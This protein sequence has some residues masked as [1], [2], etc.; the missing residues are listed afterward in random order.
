MNI[1]RDVALFQLRCKILPATFFPHINV[2]SRLVLRSNN[3]MQEYISYRL[4]KTLTAD[5][6]LILSDLKESL[7]VKVCHFVMIELTSHKWLYDTIH[8]LSL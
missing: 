2:T 8:H 3:L 6:K 4:M 7:P 5:T 1:F